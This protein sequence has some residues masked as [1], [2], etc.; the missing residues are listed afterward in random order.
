MKTRHPRTVQFSPGVR[1]IFLHMLTACNL[2]CRHCYIDTAHHGRRPLSLSTLRNWLRLFYAPEQINNLVL[3][4]GEPTLHKGLPEAVATAADLG[5][6]SITVDTNGYC[7]HDVLEKIA[8]DQ[9]VFSF[10]L[11]GPTAE[12]NDT[13]RGEGSFETSLTHIAKAVRLGFSTSVICTVSR[14]NIQVV[15]TMPKLLADLGVDR[16]FIQVIGLRGKAASFDTALQLTPDQWLNTV[17]AVAQAAA[18]LGMSVIYPK[19][20]LAPEDPFEC[21]GKVADNYFIFPNG[22]VYRCPLCED[23]PLHSL[24]I[25]NGILRQ[26][27]GLTERQLFEL[28]IPEGCVMNKLLQPDNIDYDAQGRP[29]HRISCC[30]LKEALDPG[31]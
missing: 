28:T 23:L 8:P 13:I 21:A 7:F 5:Y 18:D 10:S 30:L 26:R 2:N 11:D 16:F 6:A 12:V 19:V 4:G 27:S 15:A 29:R 31:C 3:L 9:A 1:N 24:E 22:R 25:D 14:L 17:P 20:Y